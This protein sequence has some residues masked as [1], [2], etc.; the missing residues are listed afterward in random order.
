[1]DKYVDILRL[2]GGSSSS[3]YPQGMIYITTGEENP[4][5]LFGGEWEYLDNHLFMGWKIYRK[6][7]ETSQGFIYGNKIDSGKIADMEKDIDY[8]Q[9]HAI[10]DSNE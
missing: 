8:L 10:L 2:L 3:I 7:S 6:T 4:A 9:N 1:M 5:E